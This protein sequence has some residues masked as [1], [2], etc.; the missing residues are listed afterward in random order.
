MIDENIPALRVEIRSLDAAV[1]RLNASVSDLNT[2]L[3]SLSR[4]ISSADQ[5]LDSLNYAIKD[6]WKDCCMWALVF[7]PLLLIFF[8]IICRHG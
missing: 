8:D 5:K 2:T 6:F 1:S 7:V 4:Q 3:S